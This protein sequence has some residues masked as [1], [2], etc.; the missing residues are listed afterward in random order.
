MQQ[1]IRD[2]YTVQC[3]VNT[4]HYINILGGGVGWLNRHG[5]Y[6]LF[7]GILFLRGGAEDNTPHVFAPPGSGLGEIYVNLLYEI[8]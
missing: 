8:K 7:K 5:I 1:D 6:T 4:I 3:T 2:E